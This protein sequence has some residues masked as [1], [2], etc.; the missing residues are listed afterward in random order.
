MKPFAAPV[1]TSILTLVD[2]VSAV[3]VCRLT[4]LPG[5]RS[6]AHERARR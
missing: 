2:P 6:L 3:S 1:L 4:G 5:D